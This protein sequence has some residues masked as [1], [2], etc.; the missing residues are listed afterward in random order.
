M[1]TAMKTNNNNINNEPYDIN[2]TNIMITIIR[3]R[4]T[5]DDNNDDK[6]KK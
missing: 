2:N 4:I 6:N 1:I 5:K 3:I